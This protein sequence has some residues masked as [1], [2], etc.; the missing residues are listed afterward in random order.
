MHIVGMYAQLMGTLVSA[1]ILAP[2]P[3]IGPGDVDAD[4]DVDAVDWNLMAPC[5][6]GADVST[7]PPGC[8]LDDFEYA[9]VERDGDVDLRDAAEF[10]NVYTDTYFD[11]GPWLEDK[12]AARIA[13][14]LSREFIAPIALYDRI[15]LELLNIRAAYPEVED[16][17]YH[18]RY[19]PR[20]LVV[21]FEDFAVSYD[22]FE[23]LDRFYQI[24]DITSRSYFDW[25]VWVITY[26][27]ELNVYLVAD[28]YEQLESVM[29]AA[30]DSYVSG[31]C[32]TRLWVDMSEK[33]VR[34]YFRL[35]EPSCA[36]YWLFETDEAGNILSVPCSGTCPGEC[37]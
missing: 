30:P 35:C 6:G 12:D 19:V 7:P 11:Y 31:G 20:I 26:C 32:V 25:T 10:Q 37:P 36:H 28:Q 14:D 5:L 24:V 23:E 21:R 29:Y 15:H 13:I 27:D 16:V 33:L 4:S 9:D 3:C 17:R 34:Y 18:G 1:V 8:G 2:L 22:A